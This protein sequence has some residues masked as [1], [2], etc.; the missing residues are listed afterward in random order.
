MAD[1]KDATAELDPPSTSVADDQPA[2][3]SDAAS[4]QLSSDLKEAV[5]VAPPAIGDV[6]EDSEETTVKDATNGSNLD[7]AVEKDVENFPITDKS[8]KSLKKDASTESNQAVQK[9]GPTQGSSE[10]PAKRFKENNIKSDLTSQPI[11]SDPVAIRK[12][13]DLRNGNCC[14]HC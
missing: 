13:V 3:P 11:S 12:Q 9:D 8:D 7:S 14:L 2:A 1:H 5:K 10:R 4:T 6:K